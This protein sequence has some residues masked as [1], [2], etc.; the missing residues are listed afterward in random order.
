MALEHQN[1]I[2]LFKKYNVLQEG[3]FRLTSGRHS[4]QYLQCANLFR[5]ADISSIICADLAASFSGTEIFS[6]IGPA[7]G[8]VIMSYEVSRHLEVPNIFAERENGALALR[9][10]FS[11]EKGKPYLVVEDV[12]TTGGSV[13]ET[14]N[15]VMEHGGIIAGVGCVVDRTGGKINFDV[16]FRSVLSIEVESWEANQCPLCQEG[17]PSIKPGSR[18]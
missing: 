4:N 11:I 8:A 7:L 9:R 12:I 15:L 5:H 17:I 1:I 10:G 6:V 18:K 2:E 16:P 13:V 3:H 14:M